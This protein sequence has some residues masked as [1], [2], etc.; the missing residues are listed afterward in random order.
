MESSV[1]QRV[2]YDID[3]SLSI[4]ELY[5]NPSTRWYAIKAM[6]A[7]GGHWDPLLHPRGRDGKFIDVFGWVRWLSNGKWVRGRVTEIDS[8]GNVHIDDGN[9]KKLKKVKHQS[10]ASDL[11]RIATPKALLALPITEG[12]GSASM[13]SWE[14][15]GGQGG[16]N[17]GGFFKPWDSDLVIDDTWA[18]LKWVL[19]KQEGLTELPQIPEA[20]KSKVI[21]YGLHLS[22]PG[23]SSKIVPSVF[24]VYLSGDYGGAPDATEQVDYV[25]ADGKIH[26][27]DYQMFKKL[28]PNAPDAA[29]SHLSGTPAAESRAMFVASEILATLQTD[30]KFYV[31]KAKS[32]AHAENEILANRLYEL[33]GVPVPETY[34]GRDE[35]GVSIASM[36]VPSTDFKEDLKVAVQT[37]GVDAPGDAE[38]LSKFREGM[39]VDAWLANWDV[40]GLGLENTQIVDGVPYRIDAGGALLY[41]A[42]GGMKG[43][44]FGSHVG[45]LDTF[46]DSKMNPQSA[47]A[48]AGITDAEK[49]KGA[50]MVASV[51]PKAI[52]AMVQ[53]SP[54]LPDDLA[55]TLIARRQY[56]IDE[57][58]IDDPY[59]EDSGTL[60]DL[61]DVVQKNIDAG[62]GADAK[63]E[64]LDVAAD[65]TKMGDVGPEA[66]PDAVIVP[67]K[68]YPAWDGTIQSWV[69]QAERPPTVSEAT[70][71]VEEALKSASRDATNIGMN[72]YLVD[73]HLWVEDDNFSAADPLFFPLTWP[74]TK[75][76]PVGSSLFG[77][78]P[79]PLQLTVEVASSSG[80]IEAVSNLHKAHVTENVTNGG[81]KWVTQSEV[82]VQIEMPDNIASYPWFFLTS[83]A[84][85]TNNFYFNDDLEL[86]SYIP[87]G[88][89]KKPVFIEGNNTFY[90]LDLEE[91]PHTNTSSLAKFYR[92]EISDSGEE[93]FVEVNPLHDNNVIQSIEQDHSLKVYTVPAT[94]EIHLDL[95]ESFNAAIAAQDSDVFGTGKLAFDAPEGKVDKTPDE[96]AKLLAAT[97]GLDEKLDAETVGDPD[98]VDLVPNTDPHTKDSI[99]VEAVY[100]KGESQQSLLGIGSDQQKMYEQVSGDLHVSNVIPQTAFSDDPNL[101]E[102]MVG[103]VVYMGL[104][105]D[106]YKTS[107]DGPDGE[108]PAQTIGTKT[109]GHITSAIGLFFVDDYDAAGQQ[110]TLRSVTGHKVLIPTKPQHPDTVVATNH[111]YSRVF[112]DL[113]ESIPLD[114]FMV[115][116]KPT[117]KKDNTI[118]FGGKVVGSWEPISYWND[119][120]QAVLHGEHTVTG[121]PVKIRV[122]KKSE[123]GTYAATV[124]KPPPVKLAKKK[125]SSPAAKAVKEMIS[126]DIPGNP[127]MSDGTEAKLNDWVQS[128]KGG[129]GFVGKIVGWP[130]ESKHPGLVFAVD[131]E[132]V[133]KIVKLKT[134]KKVS[135]PTAAA[136]ID[137]LPNAYKDLQFADGSTPKVGQYVKAGKPGSEI[138]GI[139]SHIEP[140]KGWAYIIPDDGSPM[141]SKTFSVTTVLSEPE[142]IWDA[143]DAPTAALAKAALPSKKPGKKKGKISYPAVDGSTISQTSDEVDE[144]LD[145]HP[146]RKLTKDGF[147]PKVGMRVRQKDGT[148]AIIVKVNDKWASNPNGLR[149]LATVDSSYT[150]ADGNLLPTT[151][152]KMKSASTTTV[153][154]DHAAELSGLD[155]KPVP[156]ISGIPNVDKADGFMAPGTKIMAYPFPI[157]YH[158]KS[159]DGSPGGKWRTA[160]ATQYV[161]L[162][163]DGKVYPIQNDYY[164]SPAVAQSWNTLPSHQFFNTQNTYSAATPQTVPYLVAEVVAPEDTD[165]IL[166]LK[167]SKAYYKSSS[168]DV[169]SSAD[170][171]HEVEVYKEGELPSAVTLQAEEQVEDSVKATVQDPVPANDLPSPETVPEPE[172]VS[173]PGVDPDAL[174]KLEQISATP[175]GDESLEMADDVITA[176]DGAVAPPYTE[177]LLPTPSSIT[178]LV[179]P[180][181]PTPVDPDQAFE[182]VLSAPTQ[183][184]GQTVDLSTVPS[185]FAGTKVMSIEEA[186]TKMLEQKDS[187]LPGTGNTYAL[188][189][190]RFV[191]DFQFRFNVETEG[192]EE[193]L[194]LRFRLREDMSEEQM[195]KLAAVQGAMKGAWKTQ[196]TKYPTEFKI[197]DA[198]AVRI[199]MNNK[200]QDQKGKM[201]KPA[202][203]DGP[204]ARIISTPVFVGLSTGTVDGEHE[205]YRFKVQMENG[206]I[207]EVD[208]QMRP[209]ESVVNYEWDPEAPKPSTNTK[210]SLSPN[211]A[212]V[213]WVD[214]GPISMIGS[215]DY[216]DHTDGAGKHIVASNSTS[217]LANGSGGKRMVLNMPGNEAQIQF[218]SAH[219]TEGGTG[220]E[221]T[222]RAVNSGEV[223]IRVPID[224]RSEEDIASTLSRA[225]EHVGLEP[226]AQLP[227]SD[228]ELVNFAL[229][230]FVANYHPQF[231]YRER[232]ITKPGNKDVQETLDYMNSELSKYLD[233]PMDLSDI[234][235]HVHESGRMQVMLSP[236]IGKAI[237]QRQ[238]IQVYRHSGSSSSERALSVFGGPNQGLM[239]TDERWSLGIFYEGQSSGADM[240]IGS[241]DRVYMRGG[242]SAGESDHI[243]MNAAVIAMGLEQYVNQYN[244]GD[245]Y[246]RRG[247]KNQFLVTKQGTEVMYKRKIEPELLGSF[248]TYSAEALIKKLK[249]KGITHIGGRPIEEIILSPEAS[250]KLFQEQGLDLGME[251]FKDDVPITELIEGLQDAATSVTPV[252]QTEDLPVAASGE[253]VR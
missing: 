32:P 127:K 249:S 185:T 229:T 88:L 151:T 147:V 156:K 178:P 143:N 167:P 144:W 196:G 72:V 95:L 193:K 41:R 14:H 47:K 223:R 16:S 181:P 38:A 197:G 63:A 43:N 221:T 186:A 56:L 214:V 161:I 237:A 175:D 27:V 170:L 51:D 160:T 76:A 217:T 241:G 118:S 137:T 190:S 69:E 208:M 225:M 39:V 215:N 233:E 71:Q 49:I 227:P 2:L 165:N 133:Q 216:Q 42:Q 180:S 66:D 168:Y 252:P 222:R 201:L 60:D 90:W 124:L 68:M 40:A 228:E 251:I 253:V 12:E 53:K 50:E 174:A 24:R 172:P 64:F 247:T 10:V 104:T 240:R 207:G 213:G 17:P 155:G 128:T 8:A 100:D 70:Q 7:A 92:K 98:L 82:A 149:L 153:E 242:S 91:N 184:E 195:A 211:A 9:G 117:M 25:D 141:K 232:A 61:I 83:D 108:T 35:E 146:K 224:G 131:T 85:V 62:D 163:T 154:V 48:F 107:L 182:P 84:A 231:R 189:D 192:G 158:T 4:E 116:G 245:N 19:T 99:D 80:L 22:K 235:F 18:S 97:L 79:V 6:V 179:P 67:Q 188:G 33:A 120:Y 194:V 206:E 169:K 103:K 111:K 171:H 218:T 246:G 89:K 11:M 102:S 198:I 129:G 81:S 65:L 203:A 145:A 34:K 220:N 73:G 23:Q 52:K 202:E 115:T 114:Q 162:H 205:T 75:H 248:A 93:V 134:M 94:G 226:E 28:Y 30:Q 113:S 132:G 244:S 243:H 122:W 150:T 96:Q 176:A 177:P 106:L 78:D 142:L 46:L 250:K 126:T 236:R 74:A 209:T 210:L 105:D 204:N 44:H 219:S 164:G 55:D 135:S 54:N 59:A 87:H 187:E 125:S 157:S 191:D 109:Y 20:K 183:G 200:S 148:E 36:L 199:G 110:L 101:A 173:T 15:V 37:G 166:Y 112:Y 13:D 230:K 152:T 234:R 86:F 31:K 58:G 77:E 121:K 5:K 212:D 29:V 21:P 140:K 1:E 119:G 26:T 238:N 130:D 139:V 138:T 3:T 123:L 239:S 45:E 57:F 136:D 159:T